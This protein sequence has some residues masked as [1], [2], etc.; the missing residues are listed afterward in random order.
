MWGTPS[1]KGLTFFSIRKFTLE[2]GLRNEGNDSYQREA[3]KIVFIKERNIDWTSFIHICTLRRFLWV[4]SMVDT[5]WGS[6]VCSHM[7]RNFTRA[8]HSLVC[9][10]KAIWTLLVSRCPHCALVISICLEQADLCPL[11]PVPRG[12]LEY[13]ESHQE[14]QSLS[15]VFYSSTR[16]TCFNLF[17]FILLMRE[18]FPSRVRKWLNMNSNAEQMRLHTF[19]DQERKTLHITQSHMGCI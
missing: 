11:S 7:P 5:F 18:R 3:M 9:V 15:T 8:M 17:P 2:K 14:S 10:A 13:L 1:A 19:T 16:P 6:I 12:N 4:L